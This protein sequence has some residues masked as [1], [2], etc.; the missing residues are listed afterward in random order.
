MIQNPIIYLRFSLRGVILHATTLWGLAGQGVVG[1]W[2]NLHNSGVVHSEICYANLSI[3]ISLHIYTENTWLTF[4]T[5]I[6]IP[7]KRGH[8]H[9]DP[10]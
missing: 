10:C 1:I 6:A 9:K 8:G 4:E 7:K 5:P 3:Y 2:M